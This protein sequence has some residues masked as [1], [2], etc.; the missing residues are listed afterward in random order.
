MF[1]SCNFSCCYLVAN[2]MSTPSR[3]LRKPLDSP[4][5]VHVRDGCWGDSEGL[6]K[7]YT[8]AVAFLLPCLSSTPSQGELSCLNLAL[9]SPRMISLSTAGKAEITYSKT[10]E[11]LS[12]VSYVD[13]GEWIGAYDG[14][15]LFP[16]MKW[17]SHSLE[18][19][20]HCFC[21][22]GTLAYKWSL[23]GIARS[24]FAF[25]IGC[26]S[27]AEKKKKNSLNFS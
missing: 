13:H 4:V 16:M 17:K 24:G 20:I 21:E 10:S 1:Y 22:A 8:I 15:E 6:K 14:K 27:A 19:F 23:D 9:K 12:F 25:I 7:Q 3:S 2:T 18:A 11:Y 26:T 5:R